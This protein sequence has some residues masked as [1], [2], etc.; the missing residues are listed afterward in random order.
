MLRDVF[1]V[2]LHFCRYFSDNNYSSCPCDYSGCP[3]NDYAA[4]EG[5]QCQTSGTC[6]FGDC[7]AGK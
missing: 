5:S 3:Q 7:T 6:F 4:N 1:Y 2:V